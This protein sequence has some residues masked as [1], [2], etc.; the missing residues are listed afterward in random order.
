MKGKAGIS[1]VSVLRDLLHRKC[2][3][4]LVG[5]KEKQK[6]KEKENRT[7]EKEKIKEKRRKRHTV[8]LSRDNSRN[9]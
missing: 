6:K 5:K 7:K 2:E 3:P 4:S 8:Y 1:R 9:S